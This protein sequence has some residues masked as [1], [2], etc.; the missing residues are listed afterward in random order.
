MR[1]LLATSCLLLAGCAGMPA[2][3]PSLT[4]E[5]TSERVLRGEVA[6]VDLLESV[7]Y[8]LRSDGVVVWRQSK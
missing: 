2:T 7:E 3:P 4:V 1:I 6:V 5:W 8:G